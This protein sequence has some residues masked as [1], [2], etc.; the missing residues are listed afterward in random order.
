MVAALSFAGHSAV[1][2]HPK[3]LLAVVMLGVGG[4]GLAYILSYRLLADEGAPAAS[5]VTYLM[6]PVS[7]VLGALVLDE[8]LHRNLVLGAV[9]VLVGVAL[10]QQPRVQ[11]AIE[12][13]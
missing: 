4:T 3:V 9:V 13:R 7:V 1:H 5:T 2:P 12:P 11:V 10:A 6:P 8:P